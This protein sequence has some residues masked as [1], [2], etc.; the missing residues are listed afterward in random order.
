ML[1]YQI[2]AEKYFIEISAV[3]IVW[4]DLLTNRY[5]NNALK[6][7]EA[8]LSIHTTC[9]VHLT[10]YSTS[11]SDTSHWGML[12]PPIN[13]SWNAEVY[14]LLWRQV[15]LLPIGWKYFPLKLNFQSTFYYL[16]AMTILQNAQQLMIRTASRCCNSC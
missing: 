11:I 12:N 10:A 1:S 3:L 16:R 8:N 7:T 15:V 6:K 4:E 5:Y 13:S 2:K 9:T 14:C